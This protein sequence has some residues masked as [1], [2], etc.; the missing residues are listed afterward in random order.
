MAADR[1]SIEM[2]RG[3]ITVGTDRSPLEKGLDAAKAQF[4][5]WGS[6]IMRIGGGVFAAGSTM[7]AGLLT[8]TLAFVHIGGEMQDMSDRTGMAVE[9]LSELRHAAG[10]SA[11][12]AEDLENGLKF[13]GRTLVD[14]A[15]GSQTAVDALAR[16][17]LSMAD[18]AGLPMDRQLELI[19]DRMAAI[20]D[21]AVRAS[22]AM[23]IFG[24]GGMRLMPLLRS[25]AAGIQ[26]L[27]EEARRLGISMSS[28][29][30]AAAEQFGDA[31]ANLTTTLKMM[32][33]HVGAS[34]APAMMDFVKE[35]TEVAAGVGHF[36]RENRQI[37]AVVGA[38]AAVVIGAGAALVALGGTVWLV[39]G[40]LGALSG[41]LAACGGIFGMVKAAIILG[42]PGMG[43]AFMAW[44]AIVFASSLVMSAWSIA[45][46]VGQATA[47]A[48][49][50]LFNAALGASSAV[51]AIFTGSSTA[52]TGGTIGYTAA[53][54]GAWI[55]ET[56]CSAGAML[57]AGAIAFLTAALGGVV[58]ALGAV[59][60]AGAGFLAL[61]GL[62]SALEVK[63]ADLHE[64]LSFLDDWADSLMEL[65]GPIWTAMVEAFDSLTQWFEDSGL[66]GFLEDVFMAAVGIAAL[67][68]GV[69]GLLGY[70]AYLGIELLFQAE[71]WERLGEAIS[72]VWAYVSDFFSSSNSSFLADFFTEAW[73][74]ASAIFEEATTFVGE[75]FREIFE[76]PIR[77]GR[78]LVGSIR[79]TVS[80][81]VG[82]ISTGISR[83]IAG[84][85]DMFGRLASTAMSAWGGIADAF[86]AGNWSLIWEIVK[87]AAILAWHDI[88]VFVGETWRGWKFDAIS[89]FNQISDLITSTFT[90]VVAEIK[91]MFAGAWAFLKETFFSAA[92]AIMQRWNTIQSQMAAAADALN[93]NLT[94]DQRQRR[95]EGRVNAAGVQELAL[96]S[97]ANAARLEGATRP[98]QI[99]AGAE[100]DRM[101]AEV[102]AE[103]R[104]AARFEAQAIEE[105]IAMAADAAER[106]PL[107]EQLDALNLDAWIG[108]EQ[109]RLEA[110]ARAGAPAA[111]EGGGLAIAGTRA[112]G[113]F[114]ADALRAM[115]GG[116][117]LATPQQQ[118]ARR[119][120]ELIR[121]N[122]EILRELRRIQPLGFA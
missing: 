54:V 73:A 121:I 82:T 22:A 120:E 91:A 15:A 56:I 57:L 29:D 63:F 80:N 1:K 27:R 59:V 117:G 51:L 23:E 96:Q 68:A 107:Q 4:Q 122:E 25:G 31:I 74:Q 99:R 89:V 71:T 33:F 69:V 50:W 77:L 85:T 105:A 114:S 6:S 5:A 16:L 84:F 2:G 47:A 92:L 43:A 19:A 66:S 76:I 62:M 106:A 38:V 39:G 102:A 116:G 7:A 108:A 49:V 70:L 53:L 86:S 30:A 65:V 32:V 113:S 12:S 37:F 35:L 100:I 104:D 40:A 28:E 112:T 10:Q 98:D 75:A 58:I 45:T 61:I 81:V 88:S 115:F 21:P 41:A 93:P 13:M 55:W 119:Q 87:A 3:H 34:L 26:S 8:A 52:A 64:S 97:A 20:E 48:A 17:G 103:M 11:A 101:A 18:L 44:N 78:E 60:V 90:T 72:D 83:T 14:A 118:A 24:R 110:L 67:A 109:A 46:T 95:A 79:D 94:A 36:V 9:A 111:G 42:V